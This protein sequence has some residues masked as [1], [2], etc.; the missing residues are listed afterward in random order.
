MF[1]DDTGDSDSMA[2]YGDEGEDEFQAAAEN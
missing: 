2:A 1:M